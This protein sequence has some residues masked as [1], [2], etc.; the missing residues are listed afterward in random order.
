MSF[1][2]WLSNLF[3][4]SE[5]H[6]KFLSKYGQLGEVDAEADLDFS[7]PH[8]KLL[9]SHSVPQELQLST[10]SHLRGHRQSPK[11]TDSA[12][13]AEDCSTSV[14]CISDTVAKH[15]L[16]GHAGAQSSQKGV[17]FDSSHSATEASHWQ[18]SGSSSGSSSSGILAVRSAS[19]PL[20]AQLEQEPEKQCEP[21]H[22][23]RLQPRPS[24]ELVLPDTGM[25]C[26]MGAI[27]ASLEAAARKLNRHR[28]PAAASN[29]Q[30][31]LQDCKSLDLSS[32][33][34][35]ASLGAVSEDE[36]ELAQLLPDREQRGTQ[37]ADLTEDHV[38]N[39]EQDTDVEEE[40]DRPWYRQGIVTICLV[41]GGLITLFMNYLD[42]LT[43]ILAS[44]QPSAGGLGMPE[45]KFAWPLTFGGLVL[46]L[47][48]LLLYPKNQKRWGYKMCCKI[49]L[50]I[51]IPASLIIPFAHTFVRMQWLTQI[52]MFVGIGVRSIA[53]IMALASSTIII[54]T[55][56]PR[57]QIGSV[58][59]ASQ[60]LN[61]LARA[62][63]PFVA[64]ILWGFSADSAI[65]GKQYL[66]FLASI[67]GLVATDIL[68]MYIVLPD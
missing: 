46:M 51:T 9:A 7:S 32:R 49:G 14:A 56:A 21:Q 25:D 22:Y 62:I 54:N 12:S 50:L 27:P 67:V 16:Q 68:Y 34:T 64:G 28:K 15:E 40:S 55:I 37:D 6:P 44:A 43:P 17:H 45:H 1:L 60:S 26:D 39:F 24:L 48:S 63:G 61:A 31:T 8:H 42:E 57:K 41:G 4:M 2:A 36:S 30:S 11:H 33:Q 19:A 47:Y 29:S 20:E 18:L 66:P 3:M 13:T 10:F 5:T 53:K 58:N 23:H 38:I 35:S 52:C 59:G 65:P